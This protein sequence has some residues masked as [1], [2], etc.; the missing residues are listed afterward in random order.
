MF[1]VVPVEN[2]PSWKAPPWATILLIVLNVAIYFGWQAPE[3]R[4]AEKAAAH[5]AQTALP[6]LELPLFVSHLA[7]KAQ[8][9][10]N[11]R[12]VQRSAKQAAEQASMAAVMLQHQAHAQLYVFMWHENQF[13][14]SLLAGK[15]ITPASEHYAE[16]RNARNAFARHEP[17]AESF[18]RHWAQS[19]ESDGMA[20]LFTRPQTLLHP[21]FCMAVLII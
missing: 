1:L 9:Q 18:T 11:T 2:K 7:Q 4:A 8:L 3:E 5:Y 12:T 16:W 21:L 6:Q 13:R 15:A 14:T 19:Y 10:N 17:P 20:A